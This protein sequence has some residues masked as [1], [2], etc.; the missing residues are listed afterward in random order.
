MMRMY[1]A[2]VTNNLNADSPVTITSANA[3][4]LVSVMAAR[5]RARSEGPG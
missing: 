1:E 5:S 4:I 2:A 3:E